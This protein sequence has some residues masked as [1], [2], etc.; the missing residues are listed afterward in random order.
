ME[1][2][3]KLQ[4]IDNS[5]HG[6]H[7]NR[8]KKRQKLESQLI[9]AVYLLRW[10]GALDQAQRQYPYP[11]NKYNVLIAAPFILYGCPVTSK[12]KHSGRCKEDGKA[13]NL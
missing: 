5:G 2:S 7:K 9:G 10:A 3:Y 1:A 11:G 4:L 13:C 12:C 6:A 8:L